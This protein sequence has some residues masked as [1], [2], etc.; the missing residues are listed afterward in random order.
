MITTP[1]EDYIKNYAYLPEH[2]TGYVVAISEGEA[3]L[4]ADYLCYNRKGYL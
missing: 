4:L 2:I 3:F 1:G